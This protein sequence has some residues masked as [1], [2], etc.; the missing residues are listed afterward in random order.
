MRT[1]VVLVIFE[2]YKNTLIILLQLKK[3][4]S[5]H[6]AKHVK[7]TSSLKFYMH[8]KQCHELRNKLRMTW[9]SCPRHK[10]SVRE[11]TVYWFWF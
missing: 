3:I 1:S 4:Y 10:M 5:H 7:Q 6:L 2:H 11:A 9:P 8:S